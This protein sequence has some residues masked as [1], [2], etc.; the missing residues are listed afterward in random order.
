MMMMMMPAS[1]HPVSS[2]IPTP[3]HHCDSLRTFNKQREAEDLWIRA[4]LLTSIPPGS[5]PFP[6]IFCHKKLQNMQ[7]KPI[8]LAVL[9]VAAGVLIFSSPAAALDLEKVACKTAC[10]ASHLDW[11]DWQRD[12]WCSTKCEANSAWDS[13]TGLFKNLG[14]RR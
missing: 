4:H 9:L 6:V 10:Q 11:A 14:R 12:A 1:D 3:P 2:C 13:V 5:P 7:S 8:L